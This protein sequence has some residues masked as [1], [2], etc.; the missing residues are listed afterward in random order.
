MCQRY[1]MI[2]HASN[3]TL[4]SLM[5]QSN[6][7]VYLSS[8]QS[9][10][11]KVIVLFFSKNFLGSVYIL[12]IWFIGVA[13]FEHVWSNGFGILSEDVV[14]LILDGAGCIFLALLVAISYF[15]SWLTY[16][17]FTFELQLDG[18]H[19]RNGVILKRQTIIPFSDIENVEIYV[20]PLVVRFLNLYS[21][22]IKTREQSHFIPGLTSETARSL[23]PELLKYSTLRKFKK[24]FLTPTL[25]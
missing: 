8:M 3:Y 2:D 16:I 20:N 19:I 14:I 10:D 13:I 1:P 5:L 23:R 15:W 24:Q 21:I 17:N 6:S 12:P 22:K 11:P 7:R 18:L 4:M 9:L 25:T